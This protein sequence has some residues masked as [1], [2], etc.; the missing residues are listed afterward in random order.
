MS[1]SEVTTF[2]LVVQEHIQEKRAMGCRFNKEAQVLKRIVTL[3]DSIDHGRPCL[4]QEL[5]DQW[6]R[7]TSWENETVIATVFRCCED[8]HL[9][10]FGLATRLYWFPCAYLHGTLL[11]IVPP[12]SPTGSLAHCWPPSTACANDVY[13]RIRHSCSPL[14]FA[15]WWDVGRAS[16]D[17]PH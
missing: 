7:K 13:H 6:T 5:A 14:C 10:W 12:F 1:T 11:N 4:S 2:E 8:F 3:Q 9:S 16:R 15:Y 17:A